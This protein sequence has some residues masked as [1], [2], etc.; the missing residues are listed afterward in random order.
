LPDIDITPEVAAELFGRDPNPSIIQA[1]RSYLERRANKECQ[2][3]AL[4]LAN[5]QMAAAEDVLLRKLDE[6]GVLS[7]K[8]DDEGKKTLLASS[9]TTYYSVPAGALDNP[10]VVR[11]LYNNGGRDLLRNTLHHASFSAF[12][13]ELA[14]KGRS[15]HPLVKV[16]NKRSIKMRKD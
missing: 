3:A 7:V 13:R 6:A 11:W 12:C 15:L 4:K 10:E 5:E 8:L 16:A 1:A 2:E 9:T 14:E